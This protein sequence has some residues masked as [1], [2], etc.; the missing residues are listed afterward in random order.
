MTRPTDS[1]A[2]TGRKL[3]RRRRRLYWTVAILAVVA[4]L[5]G[6]LGLWFHRAR[7]PAD[8]RSG[9]RHAEITSRLALGI[10]DEAP[11]PRFDDV[12]RQAGLGEFRSF[13]GA[14][15]SQ[16]PE[17]MGPGAAWGDFDN[18]GDDDLF[19]VS[20][21][22]PL[23]SETAA[24]ARS[25][26]YANQ[27]DG[28]F[29]EVREFPETRIHGMGAAWGDYDGDGW[30]DLVVTGF[31]TL[32]LFH[33]E[34]GRL[35]PDPALPDL[36]GFW[37][38]ASWA[39][40]DL[41]GDL[42]LY[43]CGY[44]QYAASA[45]DLE[46]TTR[47]Y[48]RA[49]PYTLN[50]AAYEPERNLLFRNGGDGTFEEVAAALGV[51]NTK[52]RS[53]GALWHD[54]DDDG[55][56][57]LYVANDISDNALYR[58]RGG[59]FEDQSHA[60]WV[61]DYRG[62]MGL[63]SGDWNRDGDD[64]LF[65][66][67]WVAQENA[68]YDSLLNNL[69][70]GKEDAPPELRFI[71]VADQRG[72]GQIALQVVGWGAEFADLDAD[73]WLDLVV[74][75]GST[76]ETTDTPRQLVPYPSFLF[77]SRQGQ[78]FHDLAPLVPSLAEPR[79]SRG[80]ALA[81]P[82]NDGDLDLLIVDLDGGLRL[83]RNE[84]QS[85]HW[86]E[87]RLR[88]KPGAGVVEGTRLVARLEGVALRRSLGST[89]YLSQST[90]TIHFGLGD[91]AAVP[92]LEV[93]WPGGGHEVWEGLAANAIWELS[94]GEPSP[95][96]VDSPT[97]TEVELTR[98]QVMEFWRIQRAA[99]DAF[100]VERD[101]ETAIP[102]FEQALALK[103]GHED[104]LYY[105]G[106]C[107][108]E[109]GDPEGALERFAQ[110]MQLNRMSHRAYKRWGTLRAMTAR[111]GAEMQAA[112]QA[113]ERAVEINKE[114]TGAMLVLGQISVIQNDTA[115]ARQRLEWVGRTNPQAGEAFFLLAYLAA[116]DGDDAA[117]DSY[118]ERA[119]ASRREDW[120]PEGVVAEGDVRQ[121]MHTEATPLGR[122][123]EAWDG[124]YDPVATFEAL[125]AHL[126]D[127]RRRLR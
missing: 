37:A 103:P 69:E 16:L 50:P 55:W 89:S 125:E 86:L 38:G 54:F 102:G 24:R 74:V 22:G 112:V 121:A 39:D 7:R 91:A 8:Y 36:D 84:M 9:E 85:G 17:D 113:L 94:E 96:R 19:A 97:A 57:D 124:S 78:A 58:N 64:D 15:T 90:S 101:C 18:D 99:M 20:L 14:R 104:S 47:Q 87:I 122:F 81:D 116:N 1:S 105:L 30:R 108:A 42:D 127:I 72:L 52:G 44:V 88:R 82:D 93:F 60:A 43:V 118:L 27:G 120:K 65:V 106:N 48:G 33:N 12:T 100:K 67:H 41:D 5:G 61:A 28:R 109:V 6:A 126:T 26:L 111:S 73:G 31:G 51:D 40:F 68:L 2:R 66:T 56:I 117:R 4:L 75:N 32:L 10:P 13:R 77:W 70:P 80:L 35:V 107:L 49:V 21:G 29:T 71:D 45:E 110:M 79:V 123:F 3:G 76:F 119:R 83:L 63:T 11:E 92:A 25:R 62:A 114:A 23:G 98:E 95:R 53:L 115:A 46:R 59:V 34:Q